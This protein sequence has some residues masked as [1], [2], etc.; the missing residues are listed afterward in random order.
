MFFKQDFEIV[1]FNPV[2]NK[3]NDRKQCRCDGKTLKKGYVH[4]QDKKGINLPDLFSRVF[5]FR[6]LPVI[7]FIG[8]RVGHSGSNYKVPVNTKKRYKSEPGMLRFHAAVFLPNQIKRLLQSTTIKRA[9]RIADDS[10]HDSYLNH[11]FG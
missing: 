1:D 6:N 10:D 9:K 11:L 5:L 8:K 7:K 2:S 4:E 3:K